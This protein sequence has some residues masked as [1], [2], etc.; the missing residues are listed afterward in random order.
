MKHAEAAKGLAGREFALWIVKDFRRGGL[1]PELGEAVRKR[2]SHAG[3]SA[4]AERLEKVGEGSGEDLD[5]LEKGIRE[6]V[7]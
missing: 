5:G 6:D 2:A 4:F 3:L 1:R 7:W